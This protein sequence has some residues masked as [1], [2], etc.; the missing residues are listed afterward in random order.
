MK[1]LVDTNILLRSAEPGHAMN[2]PASDATSLLR[3]QGET[4][5]IV[6]QNLYEFWAVCTRPLSANGLGKSVADATTELTN[7]KTLFTLLDDMPAL[8]PTW[9]QL[10]TV[11]AVLGKN[12][13]DARLVAAMLVHGVTHLLTFNDADFRRFT[14]I[15]VRTPAAVLAPPP[16]PPPPVPPTATP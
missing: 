10:V 4:L 7:L 9:E 2:K 8:Y 12:A 1:I 3:A 14:A 6:P 11:N 13:H 15:T 16:P 5:C